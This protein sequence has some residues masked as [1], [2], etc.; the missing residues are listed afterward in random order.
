MNSSLTTQS[1]H[2]RSITTEATN[3]RYTVANITEEDTMTAAEK[4]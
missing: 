2:V 4:A 3:D 1:T